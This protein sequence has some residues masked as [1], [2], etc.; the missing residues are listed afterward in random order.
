MKTCSPDTNTMEQEKFK[1]KGKK[2]IKK[3]AAMFCEGEG[4]PVFFGW[5]HWQHL[6]QGLEQPAQVSC[7]Q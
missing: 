5:K 2:I 1:K 6:V 3:D 4:D 7:L